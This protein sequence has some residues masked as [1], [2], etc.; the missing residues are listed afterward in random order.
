MVISDAYRCPRNSGRNQVRCPRNSGSLT[1]RGSWRFLSR[2]YEVG[3]GGVGSAPGSC[4]GDKAG[5]WFGR[6]KTSWTAYIDFE[7][8]REIGPI[9]P[10]PRK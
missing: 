1:W 4:P 5:G 6:I 3:C 9:N 7:L 2:R 10:F 8:F